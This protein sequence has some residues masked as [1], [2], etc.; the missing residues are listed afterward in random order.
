MDKFHGT[1]ILLVFCSV[2]CETFVQVCSFSFFSNFECLEQFRIFFVQ[3]C[4][5]SRETFA[6]LFK[7][8]NIGQMEVG[9]LTL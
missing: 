7:T 6:Y 2:P 9:L 1:L 4:S 3:M 5:T 8:A